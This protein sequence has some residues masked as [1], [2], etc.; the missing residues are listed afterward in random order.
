M[1]LFS[2][3]ANCNSLTSVKEEINFY[4]LAQDKGERRQWLTAIGNT[5]CPPDAPQM[6][7]KN[8]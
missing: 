4:G 1:S 8:V 6:H 7:L 2:S 3:V 5:K